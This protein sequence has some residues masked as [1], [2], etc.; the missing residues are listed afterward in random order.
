MAHAIKTERRRGASGVR[1][2]WMALASTLAARKIPQGF[3]PATPV[4]LAAAIGPHT[5]LL[6]PDEELAGERRLWTWPV[7]GVTWDPGAPALTVSGQA[8]TVACRLAMRLG[9]SAWAGMAKENG[10][11]PADGVSVS[12]I[13]SAIEVLAALAQG[14]LPALPGADWPWLA[15][16]YRHRGQWL[17]A[18]P[19]LAVRYGWLVERDGRWMWPPGTTPRG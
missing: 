9:P 6:V 5:L 14:V 13:A 1:P 17:A 7:I 8:V 15:R 2:Q 4:T 11:W 12:A 16:L 3:L 10:R 19:Q 18:P